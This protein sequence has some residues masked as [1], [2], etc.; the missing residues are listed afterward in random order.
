M[1][2]IVFSVEEYAENGEFRLVA[3]S[4]AVA[5]VIEHISALKAEVLA[6]IY[7]YFSLLVLYSEPVITEATVA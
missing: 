3:N 5:E 4:D 1:A 2:E 6:V 7:L